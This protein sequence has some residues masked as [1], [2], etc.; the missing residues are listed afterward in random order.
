MNVNL[1]QFNPSSF[2]KGASVIK[3]L[4]WIL[5]N[6]IFL[7]NP[8]MLFMWPKIFLLK[9]FGAKIGKGLVIKPCVNIKFPWKLEIG[10]Q[11][12]IGENV[13]IDNIA[14]RSERC[15]GWIQRL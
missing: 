3:Q 10:E 12:W 11:V 2:D 13:W 7:K 6:S 14:L 1:K 15:F 9:F 8:L 4:I 5:F